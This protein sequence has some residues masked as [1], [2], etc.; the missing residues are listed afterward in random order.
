MEAQ[1][2]SKCTSEKITVTLQDIIKY[3]NPQNVS[4]K[5]SQNNLTLQWN[6]PE[7]HGAAVEIWHRKDPTQQWINLNKTAEPKKQYELTLWNLGKPSA[8]HLQMRQKSTKA[9][10][11]LWSDWSNILALPIEFVK[12]SKK[13]MNG[14]RRLTLRWKPVPSSD[15]DVVSYKVETHS[16]CHGQMHQYKTTKTFYFIDESYSAINISVKAVNVVSSS[17]P[18]LFYVRP[19]NPPNIKLCEKPTP[20]QKMKKR[21]CREWYELQDGRMKVDTVI[22]LTSTKSTTRQ[23]KERELQEF[24]P[25]VYFE[26]QCFKKPFTR[27]WC[28][29]YK[30]Q[31]LPVGHP[32]N[33]INSAGS[34][35]SAT[36]CW[37]PI[38]TKEQCGL[39]TH[40]VLCFVMTSATGQPDC[41][42][43]SSSL[44]SY[45][46]KNLAPGTKYNISLKGVTSV[47]EG[48]QANIT[49]NTEHEKPY[50]V[51][52][53]FGLLIGFFFLSILF[54]FVFRR[55]KNKLLPPVP[56]P[57]IPEFIAYQSEVQDLLESKEEV[58]HVTLIQRHPECIPPDT[59]EHLSRTSDEG[60]EKEKE[61]VD[62]C[63]N[64]EDNDDSV[65]DST[66]QPTDLVQNEIALL[67]YR[68]G[69]VFDVN[70]DSA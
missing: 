46:I 61:E 57:M 56:V 21:V 23:Q 44:K 51:W 15:G 26:H 40:Y 27:K 62:Q 68:N 67:I 32:P 41:R 20:S 25:Y 8:R 60:L 63:S 33:F 13:L 42:N 19:E 31:G 59:V 52:L 69:L 22:T 54:S 45:T 4:V 6:A 1:G 70:M 30:K 14:T 9:K 17:P 58:H 34:P 39:I 18:A 3:E 38:P 49:I 11:P 2:T 29:Y 64:S 12:I 48:P 65:K 47:G 16:C 50:N 24:T 36:L 28:L 66:G 53:S 43:I 35:T 7:T 37:E 10:S 5:W 55:I